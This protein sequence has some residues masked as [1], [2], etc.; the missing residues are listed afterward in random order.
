MA[1]ELPLTRLETLKHLIMKRLHFQDVHNVIGAPTGFAYDE[2]I[3]GPWITNAVLKQAAPRTGAS[4]SAQET[5]RESSAAVSRRSR[6]SLP[7]DEIALP[8]VTT[9]RSCDSS[10]RCYCLASTSTPEFGLVGN[11]LV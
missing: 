1:Y 5:I 11:R 10:H 2:W 3:Y 4:R 8:A 6:W 7:H 9:F